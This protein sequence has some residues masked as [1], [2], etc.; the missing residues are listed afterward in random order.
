MQIAREIGGEGHHFRAVQMPISLGMPEAVRLPTQQI[1]KRHTLVPAVQAAAELGLSVFAS[2]PL[3]Q[4]QLT[5]D[6]P[7]TV[8]SLF[9]Q[10][11]T[12]AQRALAFVRSLPGVTAALVG[13]RSS[14]HLAENLES[15]KPPAL[16]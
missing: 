1:G 16:A 2:A 8:S 9:P 12:D 7:G 15:A 5:K 4:G 11:R 6:L 3:M 10:Q 14:A 13:T